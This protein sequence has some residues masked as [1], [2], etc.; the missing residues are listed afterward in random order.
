MGFIGVGR[1]LANWPQMFSIIASFCT[2]PTRFLGG[3]LAY[4]NRVDTIAH[5]TCFLRFL[6]AQGV[7]SASTGV[8]DSQAEFQAAQSSLLE[9][10]DPPEP[11][12]R[13]ELAKLD[14]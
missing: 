10:D 9:A 5:L 4:Y 14:N 7:A 1:V 13:I 2:C 3:M 11:L 12:V 8:E 6:L